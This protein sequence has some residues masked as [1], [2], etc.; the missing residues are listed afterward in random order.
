VD[1]NVVSHLPTSHLIFMMLQQH[2]KKLSAHT[3]LLL[4]KKALNFSYGHKAPFYDGTNEILA[5]HMRISNIRPV[6]LNQIKIILL[7]NTFGNDYNHL[8]SS[9]YA[10]IDSPSFRANM[11]L[12]C[13][14]QEDTI[15]RAYAAQ[16]HAP[17][18]S[19]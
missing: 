18:P 11:I 14:Q 19:A 2:H 3:Q 4:L 6:D 8:Q 5:M 15:N 12:C 7:L 13:L 9:L 17:L 16:C 1:Y 10:A